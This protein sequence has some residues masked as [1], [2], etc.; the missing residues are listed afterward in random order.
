[1]AEK[2][3]ITVVKSKK[4]RVWKFDGKYGPYELVVARQRTSRLTNYLDTSLRIDRLEGAEVSYAVLFNDY[5]C[6]R[7][8]RRVD[9]EDYAEGHY[10]S[11]V[12]MGHR[13]LVGEG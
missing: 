1:M 7:A 6:Y 2:I 9:A 5:C 3:S 12:A 8:G 13:P 4:L 11:L 10:E